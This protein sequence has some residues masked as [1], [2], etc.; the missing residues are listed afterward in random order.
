M[1]LDRQGPCHQQHTPGFCHTDTTAVP[2][3]G[4]VV[5]PT[6]E[7]YGKMASKMDLLGVVFFS[8]PPLAFLTNTAPG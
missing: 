2:M 1:A 6:Q 4:L 7:G 8:S 5:L 3:I